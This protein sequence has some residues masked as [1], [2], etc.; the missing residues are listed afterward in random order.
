MPLKISYCDL[1]RV[2]TSGRPI[3]L[4]QA[5]SP[6]ARRHFN[7][8]P[9]P[10]QGPAC[11]QKNQPVI[12]GGALG[13]LRIPSPTHSPSGPL[14]WALGLSDFLGSGFCL[15]IWMAQ[16]LPPRHLNLRSKESHLLSPKNPTSFGNQLHQP[17]EDM[18]LLHS[19]HHCPV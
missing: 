4:G 12:R 19:L 18:S 11:T 16:P 3:C 13:H 7:E 2:R 15:S 5:S 14:S 9:N 17:V 1:G 8:K 10:L 6:P